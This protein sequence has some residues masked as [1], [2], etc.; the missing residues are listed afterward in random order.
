MPERILSQ[1]LE[2]DIDRCQNVY[3]VSPC[4]AGRKDTGQAQAGGASTITLR[5]GA[6]AV[7]DFYKNMTV[8]ITGDTG[9]GQER[10]VSAYV[11]STKVATVSEVWAVVPDATSDYDVIDRPNACY[12]GFRTCQ[13]KP[14][15]VKGTQTFKFTGRGSPIPVGVAARPYITLV[16]RAPTR[17]DPEEG[18]AV[19]ASTSF[20]L[21]DEPDADVE[22]DPYVRDRLASAG[23]TFWTRFFARNLNFSGRAARLKQAFVDHGV[24][25][26]PVTERFVIDSMKGPSGNGEITITVKDPTKLLDKTKTPTPTSGKLSL[27]LGLND[28]QL[29]LGAGQGAQYASSGWVRRGDEVIRYDGK[30]GDVL[31]WSFSSYR[32]VFG[33]EAQEGKAG[34]VVQQCL[35]YEDVAFSAVIEDLYNRAGILDADIDLAGL[36][37]EDVTWLG[38]QY[39]VTACI[40]DPELTSDLVKDLLKL[41]QAMAWWSPTEQKHKFKVFA[42]ASPSMVVTKTLDDTGFLRE[43]SVELERLEAL[44]ITLC[45]VYYGIASAT[46][47]V[48]EAKNYRIA[49]VAIEGDAEGPNEYNGRIAQTKYSRWFGSTNELGMRA[50]AQRQ[51]SRYRDAPENLRRFSL[52]PKDTAVAEGQIVDLK[53]QGLVNADGSVRTAR[54]LITSRNDLGT[55]IEYA[56]R[57][58]TFDRRYGF[59][60]PDG[61]PNYPNNNGYACVSS[62]AGLM[63]DGTGGYLVI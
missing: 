26:A 39:R 27:P 17:L 1:I 36:Q 8:R 28:L 42:P 12:N 62:A 22:T 7:D 35:V 34:D 30:A 44:R 32:A 5:A 51:V 58:S 41:A 47:D 40:T 21:I 59:I 37:A 10:K 45:A 2:L 14:N 49:E 53:T 19:R 15:Y 31:S 52:D 50:L 60:A 23:G 16:Q 4:T 29:T 3:G 11:G 6:S 24:F 25:G 48:E 63:N 46:A 56:A 55:H 18:L 9:A 38:A 54:V 57:V 20:T 13:D 43:D 33:T 61:T